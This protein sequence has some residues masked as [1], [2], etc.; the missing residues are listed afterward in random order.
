MFGEREE[1]LFLGFGIE[2]L[3]IYHEIQHSCQVY[4][5][6]KSRFEDQ[7]MFIFDLCFTDDD[8][9]IL[10]EMN[11]FTAKRAE[12]RKIAENRASVRVPRPR[13]NNLLYCLV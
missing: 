4:I 8:G 11:G 3:K 10:G 6:L 13:S 2:E 1:G 7:G 5:R 9:L 12:N